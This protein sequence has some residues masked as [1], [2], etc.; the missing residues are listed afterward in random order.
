VLEEVFGS[1]THYFIAT[2][3]GEVV[4]ILPLVH[5]KSMLSGHFVTSLPGGLCANSKEAA[6]ALLQRAKDLVKTSDASYLLLRDGR[7]KWD[8]PG[9]VTDEE[10][11]SFRIDI[12]C[13]LEKVRSGFK[14]RTRQLV[15]QS[16]R[17]KLKLLTGLEALD[18]FYPVY[19]QAMRN[20]GTPTPGLAFF[21][22][23]S[24]QLP[25]N[26]SLL[27]V[28]HEEQAVGGGFIS[29]FGDVI[30]CTWSGMLREFYDLRPSH[31]LVWETIK[32]GFENGHHLV[33][34]GR[35]KK[36]SGGY[37]FKKNFG[38]QAEQLYQQ[39][40]LNNT[41]Q[42]PSVGRN[43]SKDMKFRIFTT[44]W[45]KLPLAVADVLGP[46]LRKRMPFG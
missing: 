14:K 24:R 18:V 22:A 7:K 45:S 15:N 26:L 32:Y 30:C 4:G 40:Y 35:C 20:L 19:S 44:I 1:E 17:G 11:V 21:K 6:E 10:H 36:N 38:G 3:N 8:L 28:C 43:M 25:A 42:P 41:T 27:T 12:S 34:L 5:V 46:Q 33:D 31:F 37:A 23:A 13:G 29:P 9:L 39:S 16:L 2:H